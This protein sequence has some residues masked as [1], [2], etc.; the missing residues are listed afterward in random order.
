MGENN[1]ASS[2]W[3]VTLFLRKFVKYAKHAAMHAKWKKQ[4]GG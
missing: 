2:A 3:R 1:N 4:P